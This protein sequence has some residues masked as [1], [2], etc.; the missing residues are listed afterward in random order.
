M[1]HAGVGYAGEVAAEAAAWLAAR[2]A[3]ERAGL[4]QADCAFV[5]A[6]THYQPEFA[7]LLRA[8][9][10]ETGASHL[11][12]CSGM[13]VLTTDGEFERGAGVAVLTLQADDVA[14]QSF[15]MPTH[16]SEGISVGAAIAEVIASCPSERPLLMMFTDIF[17]VY[18]SQLIE[19]IEPD[20]RILPI[21]GSA[22][23][24]RGVDRRTYQWCGG[25]VA[26]HGVAGAVWTG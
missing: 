20:A 16:P 12:G 19:D 23:D 5:F 6:T 26:A 22:A 14:L 25:E 7:R 8:V 24:C 9:R 10:A 18:P 11:V 3:M 4:S 1:I 21:V 15:L 13:G 17:S 2:R